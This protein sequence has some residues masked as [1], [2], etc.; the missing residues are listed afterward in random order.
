MACVVRVLCCDRRAGRRRQKQRRELLAERAATAEGLSKALRRDALRARPRCG[1]ELMHAAHALKLDL[2]AQPELSWIA[3]L[4]L[5][6]ALPT[7]WTL[8]PPP[9]SGGAMRY[10]NAVSGTATTTHPLEAYAGRF[11]L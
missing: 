6:V 2:V 7:G 11:R 8:V 4:A 3:E 9:A 10:R 5:L 1:V